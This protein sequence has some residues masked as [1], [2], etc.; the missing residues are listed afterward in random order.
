M[1]TAKR[2]SVVTLGLAVTFYAGLE[3]M[4][5]SICRAFKDE[6]V[7][8]MAA[9]LVFLAGTSFAS[10]QVDAQSAFEV[11]TLKRSDVSVV[12]SIVPERRGDRFTFHSA[13]LSLM[14]AYAYN[15]PVSRIEV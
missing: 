3:A 4:Q 6:R 12:M 15:V 1:K 2:L 14:I 5:L 9:T 8:A 10:A 13:P 7:V 11:A